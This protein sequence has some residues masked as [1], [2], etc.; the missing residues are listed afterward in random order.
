MHVGLWFAA[1]EDKARAEEAE[2]PSW[3]KSRPLRIPELRV[4]LL[5]P[6][7]RG[8]QPGG[9]KVKLSTEVFCHL[10]HMIHDDV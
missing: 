3:P 9:R 5:H 2:L 1:G 7:Q 4:Q 6:G 8:Q 10:D